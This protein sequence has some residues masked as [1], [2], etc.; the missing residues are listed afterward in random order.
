LHTVLGTRTGA[1]QECRAVASRAGRGETRRICTGT[2]PTLGT[3]A[4]GWAHPTPAPVLGSVSVLEKPQPPTAACLS[5]T[6]NGVCLK[7]R[8]WWLCLLFRMS[9]PRSRDTS[10]TEVPTARI[11]VHMDLQTAAAAAVLEIE[12]KVKWPL[13][14][15]PGYCSGHSPQLKVGVR[16]SIGRTAVNRRSRCPSRSPS[17]AAAGMGR[18]RRGRRAPSPGRAGA[19]GR[20]AAALRC[21]PRPRRRGHWQ[22][23]VLAGSCVPAAPPH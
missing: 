22:Q 21:P 15:T 17:L 11:D 4:Q 12:L 19:G 8:G 6:G 7:A 2:V 10:S 1:A 18:S 3:C 20:A 9:R 13:M 23:A 14:V 16:V 5:K